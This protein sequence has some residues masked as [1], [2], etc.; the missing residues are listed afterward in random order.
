MFVGKE[1]AKFPPREINHL[2]MEPTKGYWA[3]QSST[4]D[5]PC[6]NPCFSQRLREPSSGNP[7]VNS[8]G[9]G[10]YDRLRWF[11]IALIFC[12]N[13]GFSCGRPFAAMCD[14]FLPRVGTKVG[15]PPSGENLGCRQPAIV[16][17]LCCAVLRIVWRPNLF[18]HRVVPDSPTHRGGQLRAD[19]RFRF[20][21]R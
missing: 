6:L 20:R 17:F 14:Q 5:L 16:L 2:R 19:R 18:S 9:A 11:A 13:K 7:S 8:C 15:T 12:G 1:S 4:S 10:F 3:A 21:R